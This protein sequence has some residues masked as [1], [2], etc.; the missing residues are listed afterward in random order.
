MQPQLPAARGESQAH[1]VPE[2]T[3]PIFKAQ[4]LVSKGIMCHFQC[5]VGIITDKTGV[6]TLMPE[7]HSVTKFATLKGSVG[8]P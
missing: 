3:G 5:V 1:L 2:Y 6:I 4:F 8:L 7:V